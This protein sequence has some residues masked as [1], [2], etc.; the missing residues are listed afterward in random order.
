MNQIQTAILDVMQACVHEI[1]KWQT[2]SPLPAVKNFAVTLENS[3]FASFD[4]TYRN[5]VCIVDRLHESANN[6][7]IN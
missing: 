6:N 5:E 4:A 2:K 7:D 1:Q 3:L